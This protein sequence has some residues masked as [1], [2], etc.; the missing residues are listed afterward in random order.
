MARVEANRIFLDSLVVNRGR[1]QQFI[2]DRC[3]V[4]E[5]KTLYEIVRNINSIPLTT[6]EERKLRKRKKY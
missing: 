4:E 6:K 5:L 2:I 3:S 1:S